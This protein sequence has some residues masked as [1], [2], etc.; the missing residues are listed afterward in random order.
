MRYGKYMYH[1]SQYDSLLAFRLWPTSPSAAGPQGVLEDG[2]LSPLER[3]QKNMFRLHRS[4]MKL[5]NMISWFRWSLE[6][7]YLM[8]PNVSWRHPWFLE[9]TVM[10]AEGSHD[11]LVVTWVSRPML[12]LRCL[13]SQLSVPRRARRPPRI[14]ASAWLDVDC[15]AIHPSNC[16]IKIYLSY[17]FLAFGK[18]LSERS[19]KFYIRSFNRL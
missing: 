13:P 7:S 1:L 16:R 19:D 8:L 12:W 9:V 5:S 4:C 2:H 17:P 18:I 10:V 15:W 6:G 3:Q 11:P 14:E